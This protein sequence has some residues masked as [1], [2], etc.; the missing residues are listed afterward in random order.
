MAE[1]DTIAEFG[2]PAANGADTAPAA[3]LLSQ[4]VK[5]LS[6]ENPNAP[7]IFQNPTAP[8]I[9]VQFNIG[10]AKIADEVYE[11]VLKIEVRATAESQAAFIVDLSYAGLFGIRNVPEGEA[12]DGFLLGEAPRLLFPFARRV[13]ADAVRDGGFPP[14]MLEPIDFGGIYIQQRAMNE[15]G[16]TGEVAGEA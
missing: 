3:G 14:L 15:S 16:L 11:V 10:S 13:L 7:A 6:F 2:E 12:L 8:A 5:D 1:N 9:D 4:Y